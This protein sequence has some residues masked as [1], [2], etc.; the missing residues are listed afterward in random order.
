MNGTSMATPHVTGAI[1][2]MRAEN[3]YMSYGEIIEALLDSTDSLSSLNG[4]TRTGGR[5]NLDAA[6]EAVSTGSIPI[7][8][9]RNIYMA[10]DVGSFRHHIDIANPAGITMSVALAP[11]IGTIDIVGDQTGYFDYTPGAGQYGERIDLRAENAYGIAATVSFV[12][13]KFNVGSATLQGS[14]AADLVLGGALSETLIGGDG[15]DILRGGGGDDTLIGGS[16]VDILDGGDGYDTVSYQDSQTGVTVSLADGG[17]SVDSFSNVEALSGSDHADRLTGDGNDN[18]LSG[19]DGNDTLVGGGGADTLIGGDGTDYASYQSETDNLTIALPHGIANGDAQG[20]TYEG[21]E[22]LIGGQGND[23]IL[24]SSATLSLFGQSGDD[25]LIGQSGS[26]V[27][28]SGNDFLSGDAGNDTLIGLDGNDTIYGGDGDDL[29]FAGAGSDRVYGGAGSDTLHLGYLSQSVDVDMDNGVVSGAEIGTITFTGI[30]TIIYE[31]ASGG[32]ISAGAGA[33]VFVDTYGAVVDYSASDEGITIDLRTGAGAGGLAEGDLLY[34]DLTIRGTSHA[35]SLHVSIGDQTFHGGDGIDTAHFTSNFADYA[36]SVVDGTVT[37]TDSVAG[38]DGTTALTGTEYLAFADGTVT[39]SGEPELHVTPQSIDENNP[40]VQAAADVS[41][42]DLSG[43]TYTYSLMSDH[44]GLFSIDATSGAV[45]T[46]RAVD[47]EEQASYTLTAVAVSSTGA[48]LTQDFTVAVDDLNDAPV[49]NPATLSVSEDVSVGSVVGT[50]SGT[51]QDFGDVLSFSLVN[52]ADGRFSIDAS[53]GVVSVA[54]TLDFE[55]A[56][57]HEI[58]ALVTDSASASDTTTLTVQ[59]QDVF[60]FPDLVAR[61]VRLAQD[62]VANWSLET[63]VSDFERSTFSVAGAPSHGTVTVDA[64]GQVQYQPDTGYFGSDSFSIRLTD[65]SGAHVD[66]TVSLEVV[67]PQATLESSGEAFDS[68]GRYSQ[69]ESKASAKFGDGNIGTFWVEAPTKSIHFR[70]HQPDGT[71]VGDEVVL[72][73]SPE[74]K[75]G[76]D[77]V[78]LAGG[79]AVVAWRGNPFYIQ[80]YN[81]TAVIVGSDGQPI[82]EPIV[83]WEGNTPSYFDLEAHPDGGF[84]FLRHSKAGSPEV[85]ELHVQRF[86]SDGATI[87]E[88]VELLSATPG[89]IV[90]Y[91]QVLALSDGGYALTWSEDHSLGTPA[92]DDTTVKVQ[93][94]D[95]DGTARA[96]AVVLD[97]FSVTTPAKL[98]ELSNG[99]VSLAWQPRHSAFPRP[100]QTIETAVVSAD[101]AL[102]GDVT[103]VATQQGESLYLNEAQITHLPNNSYVVGW[104]ERLPSGGA[105]REQVLV[106]VMSENGDLLGEPEIVHQSANMGLRDLTLVFDEASEQFLVSWRDGPSFDIFVTQLS[107][108]EVIDVAGTAGDDTLFAWTEG[109]TVE[110]LAGDD[111]LVGAQGD[112]TLDGGVGADILNGG[113]GDD[114]LLADTLDA[115][116]S[117]GAGFDIVRLDVETGSVA[118]GSDQVGAASLSGVE[119]VEISYVAEDAD[120]LSEASDDGNDEG[121]DL[122][123]DLSRGYARGALLKAQEDLGAEIVYGA[124]G[125][126]QFW[127]IEGDAAAGVDLFEE[128]G[129]TGIAELNGQLSVDFQFESDVLPANALSQEV[130]GSDFEARAIPNDPNVGSLYGLQRIGAYDAWDKQTGSAD[131]TVAVIDS[132]IDL[133]HADLQGNLWVN[134]G[135]IWGD[136]IDNDGNGYIDDYNGYDFVNNRGIGPGYS[137]DDD[138][139]HGTHVAGTI[140]AQGNNGIGISGVAWNASLMAVKVL[141]GGGSGSIADIVEGIRYATMMGA[142]VSNNSYGGRGYSHYYT[143][144]STAI[145]EA[146]DAGSI[147]VA[148]AGNNGSSNENSYASY[149]ASFTH[150]NIVSV[151]STT[152]TDSLSY[153]SNYGATS[154]DLGAPGHS[155]YSTYRGGG[156]RTLSGTSMAAP[157]V[158]GSIALLLSENPELT[159]SEAIDAI[160]DNVDRVSSLSGRS[161]TG[162]RLNVA[163]AIDSLGDTSAPEL[164]VR[165]LIL[166]SDVEAVS[167]GFVVSDNYGEEIT[168]TTDGVDYGSISFN[169]NTQTLTYQAG[170]GAYIDDFTVTARDLSDNAATQ[171]MRVTRVTDDGGAILTG[172]AS[173]EA[174]FGGDSA[175]TISGGAGNDYLVG[176]AGDDLL[177][178]GDGADT[179]YGGDGIDTVS[180]A[181][182]TT[183][184]VASLASNSGGN[185]ILFDV[186][187]LVGSDFADT[188]SGSSGDDTL[189]GG[190]G[191]DVLDG[192]S[193][194]DVLIGGAGDD[195]LD[196][197]VGDDTLIGG[198]GADLATYT[199]D[200]SGV[201]ISLADGTQTGAAAVDTLIDIEGVI[202]GGG[203]D[204]LIG[205]AGGNE[206]QG[207]DGNDTI[208]GGAGI[209]TLFGMNGDDTLAGGAGADSLYGGDGD[210]VIY[211]GA[212]DYVNG[213]A[214]SDT[215]DLGYISGDATVDFDSG[216]VFFGDS[217]TITFLNIEKVAYSI[218]ENGT[219][220]A[221]ADADF[222]AS[223]NG[224]MVDYSGSDGAVSLDLEIGIASGGY[225]E[226]DLVQGMTHVRGSDFDDAFRGSAGN[227]TIIGG[228]GS[229]T[230]TLRGAYSDY[231]LSSDVGTLVL[232]DQVSGRDGTD[233]ISGVESIVFSDRTI[234]AG[235]GIVL[236]PTHGSA[237]ENAG[238]GLSVAHVGL[239]SLGGESFSLSLADDFDGL[240][241]IDPSSGVITTTGD[242]DHEA[243]AA[244]TLTVV[245]TGDLGGSEETSVTVT[246]DDVNEAPVDL[247]V[248][249]FTVSEDAAPGDGFATLSVN[250][251]DAGDSHSFALTQDAEGRFSIDAETGVIRVAGALDY[252]GAPSH[253][254]SVRG[255]D[256]GGLSNDWDVTIAVSDA[257][258]AP[259]VPSIA[260]VDS[261]GEHATIGAV[262]GTATAH[263]QD[264]G[265]SL[266]FAL[267]DDHGG[268]F[269]ID[270][271]S[272]VI[273]LAGGLDYETDAAPVLEVRAT[274][275]GGLSTTGSA[276]L[277]VTDENDA[278]VSGADRFDTA[279]ET[280]ITL[281]VMQLVSNDADPDGDVFSFGGVENAIGGTVMQDGTEIVFTP[282]EEFVG[283]GTFDYIVTDIHGA[284]STITVSLDVAAQTIVAEGGDGSDTLRGGSAHDTLSG[285]DGSDTLM[286]RKGNDVLMGGAGDDLYVYRIGDGADILDETVAD[287]QDGGRDTLRFGAGITAERVEAQIEGRDLVL[288]FVSDDDGS[289]A[290]VQAAGDVLRLR[291]WLDSA[292]RIEGFTFE[293]QP[294][295]TLSA[296]EM[297]SRFG[298]SGDEDFTWTEAAVSLFGRGGADRLVTGDNDDTLSGGTGNDILIAGGGHDRLDGGGPT[299]LLSWSENFAQDVYYK[300]DLSPSA[301]DV[302]SP[303]DGARV[304]R[305]SPGDGTRMHRLIRTVEVVEAGVHTVSVYAMADELDGLRLEFAS[306]WDGA[307]FAH[308]GTAAFNIEDGSVVGTNRDVSGAQVDDVGGGWYRVSAR[309]EFSPGTSYVNVNVRNG[310]A[311]VFNG[312]TATGLYMSGLQM[313]RG[314]VAGE[315]VATRA[316]ASLEPD[317]DDHLEG[318]G[319]NDVLN[320]GAGN[321]ILIGGGAENQ[322]T[323]S[324][325]FE[326]RVY[327]KDG[328]SVEAADQ[329]PQGGVEAYRLSAS[330]ANGF[331]RMSREVRVDASGVHTASIFVRADQLDHL[332]FEL[333]SGWDNA[334]FNHYGTAV[335]DLGEA[336]TASR[337][338]AVRGTAVEDVGN[339]W[340]RVSAQ[341]AFDPGLSYFNVYL[342]DG[343]Y[344]AFGDRPGDSLLIA[345]AQLEMGSSVGAYVGT[346]DSPVL[347][348]QEDGSDHLVGGDGDDRVYA[349]A[350]A[351]TIVGGS[352]RGN[353]VYSGGSGEDTIVYSSAVAGID[354]DLDAGYGR[355]ADIDRDTLSGI[356]HVVG[357]AGSDRLSG[358]SDANRIEGGAGDDLIIG[359]DGDD[360]LSGD[361][362]Q[363]LMT[364][365]EDFSNGAYRKDGVDLETQNGIGPAFGM[366]TTRVVSSDAGVIHRMT[367][368]VSVA[369]DGLHTLSA[370]VRADE[371][372]HLRFE[373]ASGWNNSAF[374]H[375]GQVVFDAGTGRVH[376]SQG[377]I[378]AAK[379]TDAGDG[380][381]R[382]EATMPFAAG[383]SYVNT[384]LHD[385]NSHAFSDDGTSGLYLTGMQF[386]SGPAASSYHATQSGSNAISGIGDDRILAGAG[387]DAIFGGAGVD[388]LDYRD[389]R[390]GVTIDLVNGTAAGDD[391]GSDVF[392]G[393][394]NAVGG[395]GNDVITGTAAINRLIGGAGAD[396][397]LA[398]TEG[399]AT[400]AARREN[401]MTWSAAFSG[402]Q[403]IKDGTRATALSSDG[404]AVGA[405][406]S[407]L[408]ASAGTGF[409]RMNRRITVSEAG[410]YTTS[411]YAKAESVSGLRF[412]M[413]SG[414]NGGGFDHYGTADFDLAGGRVLGSASAISDASV[415]DVG[416]GWYRITATMD[417]A[418]G[419]SHLNVYMMNRGTHYFTGTGSESLM[420]AGAQFE[421]GTTAG[422]YAETTQTVIRSAASGD[423]LI[424]DGQENL[425]N[426]SDAFDNAAYFK[427][428]ATVE[429]DAAEGPAPGMQADRILET[430]TIAPH[431]I[432]R[433]VNVA[434]AGIHVTSIYAKAEE[435]DHLRFELA[436]GWDGAGFAHYGTAVYDLGQGSV[437]GTTASVLG[438]DVEDV[439]DGWYRISARMEMAA[440]Q[441]YVNVYLHNGGTHVYDGDV[442]NGLLLSGLQVESGGVA[443]DYTGTT[444]RAVS[445][446]GGDDVLIAGAGDDTLSGGTGN[447]RYEMARNGGDNTIL[448]AGGTDDSLV[449][450]ASVAHDQLWFERSGDDLLVSIIGNQGSATIADWYATETAQVDTFVA[451]DGRELTAS[452]VQQ[453]VQA[454]AQETKPGDGDITMPQ[455]T[456]DNLQSVLASAWTT[457]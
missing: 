330:G 48:T 445:A 319:G 115:E 69:A 60:E 273:T 118:I 200:Q 144:I 29:I 81:A 447:D 96:D 425:A 73:E 93:L 337:S 27:A 124:D 28:N 142:R 13:N 253:V 324:G 338:G 272:G 40:Q 399:E 268:A 316:T 380:W 281:D 296:S 251:P 271:E 261:I 72:F 119:R 187:A 368:A 130:S 300:D 102:L 37:V 198:E 39:A 305:L 34:G 121:V 304:T 241:S 400:S 436:S 415:E 247:G 275:S 388:T 262:V 291:N 376:S 19:G 149:P 206:F 21:I 254:I 255:T 325:D 153:F 270:A 137:R 221:T 333:A 406:V 375:Y 431:R 74:F 70:A 354:V 181:D 136:G 160:L 410:T 456:E 156:Y 174:I 11:S 168:V 286:G 421:R 225:A 420:I 185:D 377:A 386:E 449:F 1:A 367:R 87:G 43:E 414:W 245:A 197:G 138:N 441:S 295:R 108:R 411:L 382:V 210:D 335:F 165:N 358:T 125:T 49:F 151:A 182:A 42:L 62:S 438:A 370:Y 404:L 334:S 26:T 58:V 347:T 430:D 63:T 161:V 111:V 401:L 205:D 179:I 15:A 407:R 369:T 14:S 141:D 427:S 202:A 56:E 75:S 162:G 339:G 457:A 229:D 35:D 116:L 89:H 432:G 180:F 357:G 59:V 194:A 288:R 10:G 54:R 301:G 199:W 321:D 246:V 403:Y 322:L 183:G 366:T 112:D 76:I 214:G 383:T 95:A 348:G 236:L 257:N 157:H 263:D 50:L 391:A 53:T 132:G 135:E 113:A 346:E 193:G 419:G 208:L 381:Y 307:N 424:G 217:G 341:M 315:Y 173:D 189:T 4:I 129:L 106:Q 209:D 17:G 394:E 422:T 235:S 92:E 12:V 392:S 454:M 122:L 405:S 287:G 231:L 265:D 256:A 314:E 282:D 455:D 387:N 99:N 105:Y 331:H 284:A 442:T 80:D 38:R 131:V 85:H 97:T 452:S 120:S 218:A 290:G 16:A 303:V 139:G 33:E 244:Y 140:A 413:A 252:E 395:T 8:A 269:A 23:R 110:G 154:V 220:T 20:D 5:L 372:S 41:V 397:I 258:D 224:N 266:R 361:T 90:G 443:S 267:V 398:G 340:L 292:A 158:T 345:G 30:E 6:L 309:M 238:A 175:D 67:G 239:L 412:E 298:G 299:N 429:A 101:G 234:T 79:N 9:A 109:G 329:G 326:N 274:D 22:G 100:N 351:D 283:T 52:D 146:R 123:V 167:I 453:L 328:V 250:D 77:A 47:F 65:D 355:G 373:L 390:A 46:N 147:F 222:F 249:S 318:G 294:G 428:G 363:N 297:L 68:T 226:G 150:A 84:V 107:Y 285:G 336:R 417:H 18:R 278:P 393:I 426:W 201:T 51:D 145:S 219:V 24:T 57:S 402:A 227:D 155:I 204:L 86:S 289:E 384:Y 308:Y 186:E 127:N 444:G 103:T 188:L 55:T 203:D 293:D 117:G 7:L 450:D 212:G 191:D 418:A 126:I 44:D 216:T 114:I 104:T 176:G 169:V 98:T 71:L 211:A 170:T 83:M 327:I 433:V 184:I 310:G 192:G 171:N 196:G 242:L 233:R 259:D 163:A 228:A 88:P 437:A 133:D 440:G 389:D 232:A 311:D 313:E 36:I 365:S 344:Y 260:L 317:G 332:R 342:H 78:Q 128:L 416:N 166:S 264:A 2:L 359:G 371:L 374:D 312:D 323:W 448:D 152:S 207:G 148:S 378:H 352:G 243:V 320:G 446:T 82:G 190:A 385:G 280:A 302:D 435:V 350:G 349:G 396:R 25:V 178:G 439:G 240:F 94:F 408:T 306:G 277:T 159:Y 61:T 31:D 45:T 362:T 356:E 343:S 215:L 248:S 134:E 409:H 276:T 279:E 364:W 91:P 451:G 360:I 230:L 379:V 3:P 237:E 172:D 143:S 164:S 423:V 213:G 353:D 195:V 32:T 64:D 434:E 223:T 177:M 66:R